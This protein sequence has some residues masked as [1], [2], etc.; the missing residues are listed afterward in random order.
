VTIEAQ[1]QL[2]TYKIGDW[3]VNV[4]CYQC[5]LTCG[6]WKPIDVAMYYS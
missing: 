2:G 3:F 1:V 4:F 5:Q 6:P